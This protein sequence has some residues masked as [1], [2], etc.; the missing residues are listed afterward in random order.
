MLSHITLPNGM[1][2]LSFVIAVIS[3]ALTLSAAKFGQRRRLAETVSDGLS[4]CAIV[5]FLA[6]FGVAFATIGSQ[7][8]RTKGH[9]KSPIGAVTNATKR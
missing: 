6:A 1:M 7:S 5:V 9:E 8:V 2:I 4:I 3:L